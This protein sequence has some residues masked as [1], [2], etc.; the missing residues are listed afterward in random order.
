MRYTAFVSPGSVK[1]GRRIAMTG[2]DAGAQ[3][4]SSCHGAHLQGVG[5]IPPLAGRSPT[6]LMRQ[7]VAFQ[8]G[9]RAGAAAAPMLPVAAK[10]SLADMIAVAA[11]AGSL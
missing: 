8:S 7:L 4:C 2:Q 10:L 1:R 6:Y 5:L 3:A 9:D 11:Y